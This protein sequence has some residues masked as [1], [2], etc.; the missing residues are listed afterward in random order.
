M[1]INQ[2]GR[3]TRK[4][5][6]GR[7]TN[8]QSKQ[9][10]E[11]GR[12]PAHT[13]VSEKNKVKAIRTKGGARKMRI[14]EAKTANI[15]DPKTNKFIQSPIKRVEKVEANRHFVRRNIIVK[16]AIIETEAG[17]AKVTSRPGQDGTVN[18]VLV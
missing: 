11:M 4:I 12:L 13:K 6:G 14:L 17:K 2:R 3:K 5:T 18:A 1:V 8:A 10:H 16:G 9:K 7:Y 15:L